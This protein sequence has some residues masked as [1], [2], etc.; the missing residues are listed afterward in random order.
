MQQCLSLN[1]NEIPLSKT[2]EVTYFSIINTRKD[3]ATSGHQKHSPKL[4][5]KRIVSRMFDVL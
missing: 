4:K 2:P 3:A 5:V 1:R